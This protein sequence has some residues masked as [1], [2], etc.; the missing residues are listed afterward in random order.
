MKNYS[1][2]EICRIFSN[3]YPSN[4]KDMSIFNDK[5]YEIILNEFCGNKSEE[6]DPEYL[7]VK[8]NHFLP[9][10]FLYMDE[11]FFLCYIPVFLELVK[12]DFDREHGLDMYS[13]LIERFSG[14]NINSCNLFSALSLGQKK[15]VRIILF[16]D[17]IPP[18]EI[19]ESVLPIYNALR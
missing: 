17:N 2:S 11:N 9:S 15:L 4:M 1:Y 6:I 14:Q 12:M 5:E 18:E 10:V 3:F 19:D 7:Y 8:Y 16:D 13:V